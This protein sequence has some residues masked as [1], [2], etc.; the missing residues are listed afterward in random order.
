[1]ANRYPSRSGYLL[2]ALAFYFF[3]LEGV[4]I[5]LY[6]L[7]GGISDE[8]AELLVLAFFL[9]ILSLICYIVGMLYLCSRRHD[10]DDEH[11]T[12]VLM[13]T[14]ITIGCAI[15]LPILLIILDEVLNGK[16]WI[17]TLLP[18]I[19]I[20]M[21]LG[22]GNMLYVSHLSKLKYSLP[23]RRSIKITAFLSFFVSTL[24]ILF[25]IV[26]GVL[27]IIDND[28]LIK[29]VQASVIIVLTT[30]TA[31]SLFQSLS[32]VSVYIGMY[33]LEKI[34]LEAGEKDLA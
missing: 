17:W 23:N 20:S 33:R 7:F 9:T 1:M 31:Y 29:N 15:L 18:M 34:D 28:F 8:G 6:L 26:N 32:Y 10:F 27:F 12:K 21:V 3:T 14:K 24:F 11:A 2:N 22:I 19:I 4:L 13:A 5:V 25:Y 30:I 16:K